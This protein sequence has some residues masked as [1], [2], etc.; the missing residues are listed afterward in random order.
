[1]GIEK[2]ACANY[3]V[4]LVRNRAESRSGRASRKRLDADVLIMYGALRI[5]TLK[6]YRAVA[7]HPSRALPASIPIRRLRPLHHF[8]AVQSDCDRLVLHDDVL[9]E[10]LVVLRDS[11]DILRPDILH[12]IEAAGLDGIAM[13]VVYLHFGTFAWEGAILKLSMEEDD[14]VRVMSRLD[15]Y[16]Q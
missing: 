5:V 8:F 14:A 7:D 12:M 13:G 4:S 15:I 16:H 10:P 2:R 9:R 1:M 3:P 11:L 6:S